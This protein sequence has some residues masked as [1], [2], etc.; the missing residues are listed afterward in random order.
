MFEQK[1]N[2]KLN[3]SN[4]E[5]TQNIM[6]IPSRD[7]SSF[8]DFLSLLKIPPVR[9]VLDS[10]LKNAVPGIFNFIV[11]I[12]GNLSWVDELSTDNLCWGVTEE[13]T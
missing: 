7:K 5:L 2:N 6:H 3:G 13:C 1:F 8:D 9:E 11:G 4:F 10:D 12:L